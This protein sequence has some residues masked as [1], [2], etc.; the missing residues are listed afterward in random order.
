LFQQPGKFSDPFGLW[1]ID[2]NGNYFTSDY[3][4]ISNLLNFGLNSNF[5]DIFGYVS[6]AYKDQVDQENAW[7]ND[8]DNIFVEPITII[9]EGD[10]RNYVS[11]AEMDRLLSFLLNFD[12]EGS[13]GEEPSEVKEHGNLAETIEKV[14]HGTE[15]LQN[16]Q[17]RYFQAHL[18]YIMERET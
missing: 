13:V 9:G 2:A 17:E 3:K 5:T 12:R 14:G 8:P 1:E 6:Q 18:D 16:I 15:G 11:T 10:S 4:D 7:K